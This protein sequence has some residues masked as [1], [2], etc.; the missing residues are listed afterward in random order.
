MTC[1]R[2]ARMVATSLPTASSMDALWKLSGADSTPCGHARVV[3]TQRCTARVADRRGAG[4][5][6]LGADRC[7]VRRPRHV[8]RLFSTSPASPPCSTQDRA[9]ALG[10]V[11]RVALCPSRPRRGWAWIV[12]R[13]V[14]KARRGHQPRLSHLR[15]GQF[16]QSARRPGGRPL[17][18]AAGDKHGYA[19]VGALRCRIRRV[20]GHGSLPHG[21]R[22]ASVASRTR[23][24]WLEPS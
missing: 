2:S 3:V 6:F 14:G 7:Q 11:L 21:S 15:R 24:E 9:H 12:S 13:Q 17:Y 8:H 5:Q 1:G 16:E 22:S 20:G 10:G 19:A 23:L 18:A 4:L